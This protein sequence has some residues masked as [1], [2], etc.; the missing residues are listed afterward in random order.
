MPAHASSFTAP[1]HSAS[2]GAARVGASRRLAPFAL[3][4]LAVLVAAAA[5][6]ALCVGAYRIPPAELWAALTGDAAAQ[7]ARAV[8][9]DIRAPRVVLALLVGGGF[10]AAGAAMQALFR[11]PLADPGLVGVSSG[12]A[13]GATTTIVL[14]PALFAASAGAAVLPFAAFAGALAVA[15]LVYRLAAS[16]GRLALPLL[17]LAGIAINALAGAAIGLLTFGANDAQ[18]R[19]LTFWS[20][21]SLGGAQWPALAAVTPCVAIGCALLARERNALNALQLGETEALHLGVPV[22]RLKR[23]VLVAVALAVGALVSC[24]GIIGFIG[25]VAPHC[26]RLA[27]GP[28][29]RIVMPGAALLGALLTLAADLVARTV[30]APAEIP[31][32]VLTA[33]LGAPFFLALLWKNRGAL[34]G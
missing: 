14:G 21:G 11:N 3:A 30:A 20:L 34:G 27:C 5:V 4:A 32:G 17:L 26:I 1:S 33:L 6:A 7:Q 16:R 15:A 10:G 29:Q 23:R 24:A 31:L 8:L 19:T 18:L 13:L 28:D 9:L 22:Q 2:S 12:A 25:L